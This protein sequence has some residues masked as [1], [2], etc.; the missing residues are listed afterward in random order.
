[1][2]KQTDNNVPVLSYEQLQDLI[3]EV[4][5][6]EQEQVEHTQNLETLDRDDLK[7]MIAAIVR[8]QAWE[9]AAERFGSIVNTEG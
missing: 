3:C 6:E 2:K 4:L 8:K 5:S 1:M 9:Q 7:Q